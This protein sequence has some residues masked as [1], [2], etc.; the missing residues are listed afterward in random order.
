MCGHGG[1]NKYKKI[2]QKR[3]VLVSIINSVA[4][5]NMHVKDQCWI[6]CL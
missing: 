5:I 6:T 1:E 3:D 4:K 2:M